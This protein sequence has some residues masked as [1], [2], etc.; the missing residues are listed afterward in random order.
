MAYTFIHWKRACD[1]RGLD[2]NSLPHKSFWQPFSAYYALTGCFIM[3]FVGGYTVFLPGKFIFFNTAGEMLMRE[4]SVGCPHFLV[5]VLDD[6]CLP[7]H[8]RRMEID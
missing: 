4:R 3:T 7:S 2:R 8:F 1:V 5:F 6:W